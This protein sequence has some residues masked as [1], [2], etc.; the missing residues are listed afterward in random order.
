MIASTLAAIADG[1]GAFTIEK[2]AVGSPSSDEVLVEVKAAGLCHTDHAS[3]SWKRPLVMGHE[4]AGVVR[5]VGPGVTDVTPGDRV[6][7][8]WCIPCGACFQCQRGDTVLCE[9]SRPAHV[10]EP[11]RGHAHAEGTTWR[12]R[13]VDRSFNIGTLSGLALVRKEAVTPM[14][15]AVPF[16]AAAIS[17]CGVMTGFGSVVNVAQVQR[18]ESVVVLGCGGVGLNILQ[19][20]RLSGAAPIIAV[21]TNPAALER[22]RTL[23][24]SDTIVARRDDVEMRE[25]VEAIRALT[26]GRGADYAFEA[27]SLAALAFVPLLFVRDGGLA[28]QVSGI[29]DPV[30]V[31]MP[32]FMWNK[33]YV[34]PLYGGCLPARD[35]PRIFRHYLAGELHLDE[36]VTRTYRLDQLGQALEDMLTGANAKGVIV[37]GE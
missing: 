21:D 29:N 14:P 35:F 32:W 22:A 13:P 33:R 23:G 31:P 17:G 16:P 12:G 1:D 10:L 19:G 34:T 9:T 8:N 26:D 36:L 24:A 6:V 15:A 2:I 27:T 37:F 7:L 30:T 25:V 20:A 5:E 11:S 3:L 4:G 18:G 28:L